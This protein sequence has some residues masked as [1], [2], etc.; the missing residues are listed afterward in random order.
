MGNG[1]E[2]QPRGTGTALSDRFF[3]HAPGRPEGR[4]TNATRYLCAA[5]YLNPA[6]ANQVIWEL[7]ASRRA[8]APSVGMD[9]GPV[10]RHCLNARRIQLTRDVI[11]AILLVAGLIVATVPTLIVLF[12]GFLLSLLP[13]P[14]GSAI[15]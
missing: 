3:R 5:A 2:R 9:L 15:R 4:P 12:I 1:G 7:V 11:L 8:V 6:Y 13:A 14:T 10:I